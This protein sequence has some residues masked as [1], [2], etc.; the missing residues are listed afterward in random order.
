H[1]VSSDDIEGIIKAESRTLLTGSVCDVLIRV[2]LDENAQTQIEVVS[3][4]QKGGPDL[5][6]NTRRVQRFFRALDQRLGG[7]NLAT[8]DR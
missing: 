8:R 4:P 7:A 2:S 1:L 6:A 3:Q 5:G